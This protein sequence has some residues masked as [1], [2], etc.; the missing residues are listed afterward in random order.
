MSVL[1]YFA[2]SSQR[3]T[4]SAAKT[5]PIMTIVV[6]RSDSCIRRRDIRHH[7]QKRGGQRGPVL[8]TNL[9]YLPK[10]MTSKRVE[11]RFLVLPAKNTVVVSYAMNGRSLSARKTSANRVVGQYDRASNISTKHQRGRERAQKKD[12]NGD[13]INVRLSASRGSSSTVTSDSF[14]L[15]G[16]FPPSVGIIALMSA[17]SWAP[18]C[19][20]LGST[21]IQLASERR[22][23]LDRGRLNLPS[24]EGWWSVPQSSGLN[25]HL[26]TK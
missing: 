26:V 23:A 25:R 6:E 15:E 9:S 3:A 1:H 22:R 10:S 14:H 24:L 2:K 19:I 7:S 13:P 4:T 17:S 20:H 11:K 18:L 8:R 16:C 21:R 12:T 5:D